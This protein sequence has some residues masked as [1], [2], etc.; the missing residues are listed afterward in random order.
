MLAVVINRDEWGEGWVYNAETGELI[1]RLTPTFSTTLYAI[2]WSPDSSWVALVGRRFIA[3]SGETEYRLNVFE[4]DPSTDE[5]AYI[6][7]VL[8]ADTTFYHAWHPEG[9]LLA[10]TTSAG[11]GIYSVN[12]E[13]DRTPVGVEATRISLIPDVTGYALAWSPDG[14]W[15]AGSHEDGT[16][17]IWDV[18]VLNE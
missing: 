13:T 2:S 3:G 12:P 7:T 5:A 17:R 6:T 18:M 4:V 9:H 16:V 10:V 11:V 15:L 14:S 8:D 1:N